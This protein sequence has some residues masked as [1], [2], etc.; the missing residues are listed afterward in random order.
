MN[1]STQ[2]TIFV[3]VQK[4][5]PAAQVP[6][7][8][9]KGAACFDLVYVEDADG[10]KGQQYLSGG[11][12]LIL[13]T[14]LAFEIPEGYVMY[15]YSRSGHG[16]KDHIRL[17][18]C[19]GIIDS[20]YRGEVKVSLQ[21]DTRFKARYINPGEKIAQAMVVPIPQVSFAESGALSATERGTGGFGS[22]GN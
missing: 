11:D 13:G 22:T 2:P 17:S 6:E 21:S 8:A 19:V 1:G 10:A 9:T 4:L 7:Y 15:V 12:S 14:G 20:D 3:K 16:F 18:N 5:R